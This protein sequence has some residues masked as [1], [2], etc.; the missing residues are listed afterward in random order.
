MSE[1]TAIPAP[2]LL[3]TPWPDRSKGGQHVGTAS[4]VRVEHVPTGLVAIVETER[5]QHRNKEIAVEMILGGLTCRA[6]R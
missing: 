4:G 1:Q 6:F 5:S 2:D 3:I